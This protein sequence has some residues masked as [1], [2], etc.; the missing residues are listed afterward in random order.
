MGTTS[1]RTS[2][3]LSLSV[4]VPKIERLEFTPQIP[5][6]RETDSQTEREKKR[7]RD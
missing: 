1:T 7:E 2:V 4:F 5:K 3:C 6:E